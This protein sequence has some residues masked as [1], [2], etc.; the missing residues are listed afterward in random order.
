MKAKPAEEVVH[1]VAALEAYMDAYLTA[2]GITFEQWVPRF[3]G[4]LYEERNALLS[5]LLGG[6]HPR[7]VLEFACAGP[8][9]ARLLLARHPGI[10]SYA[11]TNFSDRMVDF[12][13]A[14]FTGDARFHASLVDADVERS[15]DMRREAVS[16]FDTFITT[17]LE[18]IPFDRELV[19]QLPAGAAFV[20]SVAKFDDPEHFRI[21]DG[22]HDVVARYGDLLR[23][24]GARETAD[25]L[26]LVVAA[27]RN[28]ATLA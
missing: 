12:C 3:A 20:F 25:H 9:L 1:E 11:C 26:K 14:S 22:V 16:V 8:Y 15:A 17:S 18:H 21:F 10:V 19:A 5:E 6:M 24:T 4:G 23:V 2:E 13:R 27:V 28:D 7:Q